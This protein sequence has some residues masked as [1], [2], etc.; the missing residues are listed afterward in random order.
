MSVADFQNYWRIQHA[1][2]VR[3]L[4]QMQR[5]RQN[6]VVDAAY[7]PAEPPF[8]GIAEIWFDSIEDAR[9]NTGH[10]H[11]EVIRADEANF[12]DPDSMGSLILDE[13]IVLE[14]PTGPVGLKLMALIKRRDGISLEAFRSGYGGE[15]APLV[16]TMPGLSG[17]VQAYTR[18]GAYRDGREPAFDALASVYFADHEAL[19]T[20]VAAV[21]ASP[22]SALEADLFG[23][24][25]SRMSLVREV[26]IV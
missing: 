18:A 9:A 3:D 11:L 8:D 20:F 19:G 13:N 15:V 22:I 2:V 14:P 23:V 5:Y 24:E 7:D 26:P 21:G 10:P 6:H 4:P 16:A 25:T 12:I 17:Y 1:T